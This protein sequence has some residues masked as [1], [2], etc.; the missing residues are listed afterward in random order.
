MNNGQIDI[1]QIFSS[2]IIY[3][4]GAEIGLE[5]T[6]TLVVLLLLNTIIWILLKEQYGISIIKIIIKQ[7]R[8]LL[9]MLT[10]IFATQIV[11]RGM[12]LDKL[13]V[14]VYWAFI[15]RLIFF[16]L[17]MA[18]RE[19]GKNELDTN[20]RVNNMIFARLFKLF[21]EAFN[22]NGDMADIDD[23]LKAINTKHI[24]EKDTRN[25]DIYNDSVITPEE[26]E[27]D[28]NSEEVRENE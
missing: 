26:Q 20:G 3:I 8:E 11:A 18:K 13:T 12:G 5:K 21:G 4:V 17:Y 28:K 2:I 10:L 6:L 15:A 22:L 14:A 23:S 27:G 9:V 1:G 25:F 24:K 7:F 19:L 16:L